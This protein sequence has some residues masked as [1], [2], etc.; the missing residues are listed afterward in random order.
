MGRKLKPAILACILV[1]SAAGCETGG[2][3]GKPLGKTSPPSPMGMLPDRQTEAARNLS[4]HRHPAD[5]RQDTSDPEN[6]RP[7]LDH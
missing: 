5:A 3:V 6:D 2:S 1:L 7:R 4:R